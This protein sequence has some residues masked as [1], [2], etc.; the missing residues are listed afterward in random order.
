MSFRNVTLFVGTFAIASTGGC[1]AKNPGVPLAPVSGIVTVNGEPLT[2]AV[3]EFNPK[4]PVV[5]RKPN[6]TD[7]QK[8]ASG[9]SIGVTDSK[10]KYTLR[11]SNDHQGAI[12][13]EH[14]IKV[15]PHIFDPSDVAFLKEKGPLYQ[16]IR[17]TE[18]N[19]TVEPGKKSYDIE[20]TIPDTQ[21]AS[22]R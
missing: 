19:F 10:G 5:L 20:L 7:K 11:Y 14:R 16:K 12:V 1:G 3:V 15:S 13:G 18:L 9:G 6:S 21:T 8:L 2:N 4:E 22:T 17:R